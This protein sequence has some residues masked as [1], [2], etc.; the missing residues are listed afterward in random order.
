MKKNRRDLRR[1]KL[2]D[3]ETCQPLTHVDA[4]LERLTLNDTSDEATGE[5]I[6]GTVGVV[7]LA[8]LDGVDRELLNA[9]LTLNGN[10]GRVGALGDNGN[11]LALAILL[12]Q[13]REV[14]DDVLGL[15]GRK[16]VRFGV[17]GG[18]GLVADDVVPV[19]GAGIDNVLEELGD[20]GG[21]ERKD[22]G[23]VVLGG[24][25]GKLHDGRRGD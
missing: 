24:L 1:T 6:T 5:G 19:G 14:L 23:L 20:E 2:L 18:L 15:L 3:A 7:D 13:V 25:L 10:K 8:R 17:G 4:G 22:E 12:G 16:L 11:T 21:R 9:V